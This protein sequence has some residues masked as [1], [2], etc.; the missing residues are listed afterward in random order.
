AAV[1]SVAVSPDGRRVALGCAAPDRD[2]GA[3]VC[4]LD[5]NTGKLV[6]RLDRHE[7]GVA[8][9]RFTSDG[10]RLVSCD[11][12]ALRVWDV[13]DGTE[14]KA[15][16]LDASLVTRLFLAPDGRRALLVS[17]ADLLWW[18]L[19]Q[20]V[21]VRRITAE[22]SGKFHAACLAGD[23]RHALA[24]SSVQANDGAQPVKGGHTVRLFDLDSGTATQEFAHAGRVNAVLVSP[25]GKRGY[26]ADDA[27][28]VRE[29]P[30]VGVAVPKLRTKPV[31]KAGP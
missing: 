26:T 6:R 3:A 17:G 23:G 9:V 19:E 25:D 2:K 5:A 30:L 27:G 22:P 7:G 1:R 31:P 12:E 13:T 24:S 8:A 21:E 18:D 11:A 10:R 15:Q 29:W 14:V 28:K 16:K 20:G 4:L